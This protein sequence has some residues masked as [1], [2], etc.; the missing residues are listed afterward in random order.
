MTE[1]YK[2]IKSYICEECYYGILADF[3]DPQLI[4]AR[5]IATDFPE[6]D[7][8]RETT[9][10]INRWRKTEIRSETHYRTLREIEG[11]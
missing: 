11:F 8:T 10:T 5:N 4:K 7:E 9:H 1:H 3:I 6:E 2:F